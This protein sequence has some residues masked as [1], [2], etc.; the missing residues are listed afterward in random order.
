MDL[1]PIYLFLAVLR[2]L[3]L[4]LVLHERRD[5]PHVEDVKQG[6]VLPATGHQMNNTHTTG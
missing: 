5:D 1:I 6:S 4:L 2:K 3:S